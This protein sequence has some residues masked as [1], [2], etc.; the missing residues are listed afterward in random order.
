MLPGQADDDYEDGEKKSED[1]KPAK[2]TTSPEKPK[3]PE[4]AHSDHGV[5]QSIPQQYHSEPAATDD[6]PRPVF[7]TDQYHQPLIAAH[8]GKKSHVWVFILLILALLAVGG[9]LGY[10]AFM[11]GL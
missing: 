7:D 3:S 2:E 8:S 1:K 4:P 6:A 11:S 9:T 10:F 5:A